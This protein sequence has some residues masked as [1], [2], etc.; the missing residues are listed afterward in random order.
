MTTPGLTLDDLLRCLDDF[1][2]QYSMLDVFV[3]DVEEMAPGTQIENMHQL[4][5]SGLRY[6]LIRQT[7]AYRMELFPQDGVLRLSKEQKPS[8]TGSE[9]A[10]LGAIVGAVAGT[11]AATAA[12]TSAAKKGAGALAGGALGLL[13]GAALAP[14]P[15]APRRVFTLQFD[16]AAHAWVPY[17]GGLVAW[18]KQNLFPSG[19]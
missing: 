2:P 13:V 9:A 8:M 7:G 3:D 1:A 18:M 15:D 5:A 11:A 6:V 12:G 4:D 17:D 19:G 14:R 10:A 16:P